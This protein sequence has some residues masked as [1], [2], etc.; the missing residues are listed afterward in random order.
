[1]RR[2]NIA[3]RIFTTNQPRRNREGWRRWRKRPE[4]R[5]GIIDMGAQVMAIHASARQACVTGTAMKL[6][7]R[8]R[9]S[10]APGQAA[11]IRPSS[12]LN[13]D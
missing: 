3:P 6:A 1:M 10:G 11:V 2:N 13:S 9:A 4:R 7:G 12:S 5:R 8:A